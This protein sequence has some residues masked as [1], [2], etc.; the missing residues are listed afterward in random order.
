MKGAMDKRNHSLSWLELRLAEFV[1]EPFSLFSLYANFQLVWAVYFLPLCGG[2]TNCTMRGPVHD[3]R[4]GH[5]DRLHF[6]DRI[7]E[8]G[9]WKLRLLSPKNANSVVLSW[10]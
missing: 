10:E 7:A 3:P 8:K 2:E 1:R 6:P 9:E 4:R 5:K